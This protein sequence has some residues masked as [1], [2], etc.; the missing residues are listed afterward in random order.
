[1]SISGNFSNLAPT[2]PQWTVCYY[3]QSSVY[4]PPLSHTIK[5]DEELLAS[6]VVDNASRVLQ[7]RG[8]RGRD[9]RGR[10]GGGAGSSHRKRKADD[11]ANI[12][13]EEEDEEE[14]HDVLDDSSSLHYVLTT[15]SEERR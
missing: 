9:T 13:D 15:R 11:T 4:T 10:G 1:M 6:S 2:E 5:T 3:I 7:G 8:G 12:G 14:D